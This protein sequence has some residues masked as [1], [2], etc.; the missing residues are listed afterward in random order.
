MVPG[1]WDH[2]VFR[3]GEHLVA[4]FPRDARYASQPLREA[5]ALR[6]VRSQL[7]IPVPCVHTVGT[8]CEV[9][10][11]PFLIVEWLDGET[12]A[13]LSRLTEIHVVQLA[14]LLAALSTVS[15]DGFDYPSAG[16]FWRGAGLA[17]LDRSFQSASGRLQPALCN[18]V[19][20]FWSRANSAGGPPRGAFV[21][22]DI[23]PANLIVTASEIV[24]VIDFG[25]AAIGD[26]ACDWA[27]AWLGFDKEL[28]ETFLKGMPFGDPSLAMRAAA[29]AL[30]KA[31]LV[32]SGH[33][34]LPPGYREPQ[35]VVDE[36]LGTKF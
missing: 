9:F 24:G 20:E 3:V 19:R 18:A 6:T 33:S 27:I 7:P 35:V 2:A 30:W 26:P 29:W 10:P 5:K 1:G 12:M 11:Y 13:N 14:V 32:M 28:R 4:K 16:N 22:G 25:L 23:A 31:V 8:A 17:S 36:V 34:V 21:H 15:T